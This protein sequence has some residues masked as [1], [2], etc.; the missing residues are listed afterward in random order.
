MNPARETIE[1]GSH[2]LDDLPEG[3]NDKSAHRNHI[4]E[5]ASSVIGLYHF[6]VHDAEDGDTVYGEMRGREEEAGNRGYDDGDEA[7]RL[8]LECHEG[9]GDGHGVRQEC[10]RSD[11]VHAS[12]Y[13]GP[14]GVVGFHVLVH[15]VY[16]IQ[17]QLNSVQR[18]F[19]TVSLDCLT[20]E[21]KQRAAFLPL[22][23]RMLCLSASLIYMPY[24]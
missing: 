2:R 14:R 4:G 24:V 22:W 8:L 5:F 21:M 12:T 9:V 17:N 13:F 11:Q 10:H 18:S 1:N 15:I 19:I 23:C 3:E 6:Q 7:C 20:Q 16:N